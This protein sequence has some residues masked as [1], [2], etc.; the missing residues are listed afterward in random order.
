MCVF[1]QVP[2]T[3]RVSSLE[4]MQPLQADLAPGGFVRVPSSLCSAAF[5]QSAVTW[6]LNI[7]TFRMRLSLWLSS[8]LCESVGV[9]WGW[10]GAFLWED[11]GLWSRAEHR[12][13]A[14]ASVGPMHGCTSQGWALV[15]MWPAVGLDCACGQGGI[16]R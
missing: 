11:T 14:A 8:Y 10:G 4:S 7:A 15:R 3:V 9:G 16:R 6:Y 12:T 13:T 5:P 2:C 1:T